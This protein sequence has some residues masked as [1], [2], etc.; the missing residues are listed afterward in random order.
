M[1]I[2]RKEEERELLRAF[3]SSES[4]FVAVYGRR[5]VGKTFLVKNTFEGK[6]TFQHSGAAN[7]D[8]QVQLAAWCQSLEEYGM[9]VD[10]APSNWMDAFQLL[11]QL[12]KESSQE[13]KVVFIDEMPWMDTPGSKFTTALEFFWNSFA[14]MRKDVLL[15]V[16]G[17]AASWIINKLFRNYGGLYNRVRYQIY[18]RPFTLHEC[19]E[20]AK[21]MDLQFT[22]YDILEA[23]MILG[24]I[25]YYWSLLQKGQSLAGNIDRLF[26][27]K[28][29]K[30]SNE[31]N[32]LYDSLFRRP[33]IYVKIVTVLGEHKS[34]LTRNEI[35]SKAGLQDNGGTS[36]AL[37]D[38]E[39][40]DFISRYHN[41]STKK[42]DAIFRLSDNLSLFYFK[43]IKENVNNDEHFWSS[44]YNTSTRLA[45]TG[46]AFER[47]C[48][49][50]IKQIKE[51]LGIRGVVTNV[52]S[53]RT[54][55]KDGGREVQIDMLIDRA[56]NV[57]NLCEMKFSAG[58]FSISKDYDMEL[59]RKIT[60]FYD[61]TGTKKAVHLT[62]I[63]PYGVEHNMYWNI[64][65]S[66]VVADDL[67]KE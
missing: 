60:R 32:I 26:F 56:D 57:V 50:H 3:E 8:K 64:V 24:G 40:S 67:F 27:K 21:S 41:F 51:A 55:G 48:F 23:Y 1:I 29:G 54:K 33:E 22:R 28:N 4:E 47:V 16:C 53:C 52:L 15:I 25:P 39:H 66:E 44:V 9:T 2:R 10:S 36:R 6:F 62:L 37:E 34:G 5:R 65:Q 45:W 38:L 17:S 59:R 7:G 11:R 30:L 46:L 31:F 35:I 20:Y 42:N 13:K 12:I 14:S 18:L 43:F 63:T 49:Q 58:P 19:E 61:T